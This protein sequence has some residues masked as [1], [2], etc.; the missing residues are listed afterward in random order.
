LATS[1]T[2][3]GIVVSWQAPAYDGGS[4]VTGYKI[5]RARAAG[6]ESLYA[7]VACATATCT[8]SNKHARSET[9]FF[10]TVA[11]VNA[12]GTGPESTQ[13]SARAR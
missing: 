11:A 6:A 2:V 5:Y 10:Y 13:A 1:S 8:Y 4:P 7:T 9:M 12:V 3:K